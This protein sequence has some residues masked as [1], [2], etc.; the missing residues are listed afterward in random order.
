LITTTSKDDKEWKGAYSP[1][2][3]VSGFATMV[4]NSFYEHLN[5]VE[6]QKS[7]LLV[8]GDGATTTPPASTSASSSSQLSSS[9]QTTSTA[10]GIRSSTRGS[11]VV[12]QQQVHSSKTSVR[13]QEQRKRGLNDELWST[14]CS[15]G[16]LL[17]NRSM[18]SYFPLTQELTLQNGFLLNILNDQEMKSRHP[19]PMN[20]VV[21]NID[22]LSRKGQQRASS[23]AAENGQEAIASSSTSGSGIPDI[24]MTSLALPR[25]SHSNATH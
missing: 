12:G 24:L 7:S 4:V 20:G 9:S 2:G 8:D 15:K 17:D 21:S 16:I 1:G 11:L 10:G 19:I 18:T 6:A 23:S 25:I 5:I 22:Q 14:L 13:H 3:K